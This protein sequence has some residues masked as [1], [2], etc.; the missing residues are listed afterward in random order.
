VDGLVQGRQRLRAQERGRKQLVLG[1][2]S[3]P[4]LAQLKDD[5]A[6]NPRTS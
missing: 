5:A 6:V 1:R 3:N 4:S 2:G